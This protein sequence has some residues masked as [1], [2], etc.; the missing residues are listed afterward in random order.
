LIGA[1]GNDPQTG[2]LTLLR[3]MSIVE[4]EKRFSIV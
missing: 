3:T 4:R 1:Q 2:T